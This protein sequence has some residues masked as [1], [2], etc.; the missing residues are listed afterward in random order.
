MNACTHPADCRQRFRVM[1]SSG[2]GYHLVEWCRLCNQNARGAGRW[3]P[4]HAC[5]HDPDTLP[6][7][8]GPSASSAPPGE[9]LKCSRVEAAVLVWF[10]RAAMKHHPDKGGDHRVMVAINDLK[11]ALLEVLR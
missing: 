4:R 1:F 10:R 5:P 11:D 3:A 7:F 8:R 9:C 6:V 2:A